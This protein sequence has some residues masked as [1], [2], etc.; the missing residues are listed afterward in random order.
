MNRAM[1]KVLGLNESEAV[2]K[3][4]NT[5]FVVVGD[6]LQDMKE[7]I[8]SDPAEYKIVGV[9]PD[10]KTPLFYVPFIDLRSLGVV[11]YSQVKAVTKNKD[12]LGKVRQQIE[13]MGYLT[14]SVVDTVNQVNN[15]FG[16]A[17]TVLALVGMVAL[18]VASLGMFNTL[19]V[20]LLERTREV[21]LMKAMGMK[22]I[23][24]RELFLTESMIMGF[25][26][27]I[28]GIILGFLAGKAV[29]LILSAYALS[30]GQG[31]IDI[32]SIPV[33]FAVVV[34]LLSLTVGIVTGIY[35]ARRAKK[36]SALDALRYE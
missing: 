26:G 22:S 27:G 12:V 23:E 16:T 28:L 3:T 13:A 32:S 25:F 2:G 14:H 4:F 15:I 1:L 34:I 9:I 6:L 19:T 11:N 31:Y 33:Y 18:A 36:I 21:G 29:G 24:V 30:K 35:P 20:S 7:K 10:D 17:R 5:S 8:E